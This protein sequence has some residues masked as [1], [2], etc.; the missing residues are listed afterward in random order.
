MLEIPL[1]SFPN[2]GFKVL[3]DNQECTIALYQKGL[4]MYMDLYVGTQDVSLGAV[5]LNAQMIVQVAQNAFTGNFMFVD[6]E[7][8]KAPQWDGLGT[9][10]ILLY[11][12]KSEL[13]EVEYGKL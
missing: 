6:L 12:T 11:F 10:Y 13:E 2:S 4:R 1:S 8:D 9:R 7:G 3:L 5:C